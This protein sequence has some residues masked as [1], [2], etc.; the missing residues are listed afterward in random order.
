[1]ARTASV[2]LTLAGAAALLLSAFQPWYEG[3]EP[4]EVKLTD[5]FTGLEPEAANGTAGSTLLL[6]AGV[7]AVAVLGLLP[8]VPSPRPP[9][10]G[11][12]LPLE[13]T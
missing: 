7:A 5:L 1:M 3:R 8:G 10:S 2:L 12:W 13:K 9:H 4:G 6:L 11:A